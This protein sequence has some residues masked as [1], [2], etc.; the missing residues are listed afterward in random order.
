MKV[1]IS[2]DIEG[3]TGIRT[4]AQAT[5]G[6]AEYARYARRM[7]DEVAAACRGAQKA[8]AHDIV[9]R[10]AHDSADNLDIER[11]PENVT[12]IS[13][14]NDHPHCM[15]LGL[16]ESFDAVIMIGYHSASGTDGN[17]LA[18]TMS[19][20]LTDFLINNTR[21]GEFEL[22][23]MLASSL[24]VPV[25]FVS[26]D[27]ALIDTINTRHKT[28]KTVATQRAMGNTITYPHP[29]RVCAAIEAGVSAALLKIADIPRFDIPDQFIVE[30]AFTTNIK[31][32]RAAQYPGMEHTG[33]RSVR[34]MTDSITEVLRMV[35]FTLF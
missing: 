29:K 18:H 24:G 8:G 21:V 17:P 9:V 25:V 2:A 27:A 26:G 1:L 20:E 10:D 32:Y 31:A 16:D 12:F 3:I 7:T 6:D 30:L 15:L 34:Y 11:L 13:G 5:K 35:Q 23:A 4:W 14:F 28:L 33:P 19:L 22:H